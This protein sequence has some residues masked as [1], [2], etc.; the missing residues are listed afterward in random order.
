MWNNSKSPQLSSCLPPRV[1]LPLVGKY[2][3]K[4]YNSWLNLTQLYWSLHSFWVAVFSQGIIDALSVHVNACVC[5]Y[6][7]LKMAC[8]IRS[9]DL[10]I[11]H[12][13]FLLLSCPA[14]TAGN[15]VLGSSLYLILKALNHGKHNNVKLIWLISKSPYTFTE[16][17]WICSADFNDRIALTTKHL[18]M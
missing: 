3:I 14:L 7:A 12:S 10:S 6:R 11:S 8:W 15:W 1:P 13:L 9:R 18:S 16:R 17:Y 4:V 2:I 5:V